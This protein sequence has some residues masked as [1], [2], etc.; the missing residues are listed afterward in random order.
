M[1][2]RRPSLRGNDFQIIMSKAENTAKRYPA[3]IMG[4]CLVPWTEKW[5]FDEKT[6]RKQVRHL[7]GS[8]T[9]HLYVFG[10]AGEGYAVT[11]AQFEAIS[12]SFLEEA[13]AAGAQPII[14]V[15]SLS[16]PVI[17]ERIERA[18]AWGATRFQISLPSWGALKD[19]EV[20]TFFRETCG[21]F[22]ECEFMHYNLMRTKRLLTPED[23]GR[24]AMEHANFVASKNTGN[25]EGF[26][27]ALL[28]KAPQMQHF[29]SESGYTLMRDRLECGLLISIASTNHG[30]A[31]EFF[32]ARGE[33]LK[34]LNGE[35]RQV[36]AA[37]KQTVDN[38]AHIDGAFDKLIYKLSS[39]DFPLRLLPPY[40][41]ADENTAL[42]RCRDAMTQLAPAWLPE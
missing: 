22:Q 37:L 2:L 29:L 4:A 36:L 6:F 10:T 1:N 11:D 20:E 21:R 30:R 7:A 8:L 34:E 32:N 31:K 17:L 18:I 13:H 27:T 23:Y 16:L 5:A 9:P 19:E 3:A 33:R 12:R 40:R 35:L 25:D 41:S 42:A 15:I 26:L 39:P 24:L 28:T 14:G 38:G